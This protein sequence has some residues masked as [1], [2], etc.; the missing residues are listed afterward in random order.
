VSRKSG[1]QGNQGWGQIRVLQ[2]R[3]ALARVDLEP[4]SEGPALAA[5]HESLGPRWPCTALVLGDE[6]DNEPLPKVGDISA[7]VDA[8]NRRV[9][10]IE[11]TDVRVVRLADVDLKHALD[12]GEGDSR[13][14]VLE[15]LVKLS[16]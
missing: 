3:R 5:G 6:G 14:D 10:A 1:R 16:A 15:G 7:V 12:E 13:D 11:L 2:P 8:K 9:A 4:E